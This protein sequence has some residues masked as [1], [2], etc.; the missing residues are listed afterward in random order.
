MQDKN[1]KFYTD[2]SLH[3][4]NIDYDISHLPKLLQEIIKELE[5][6]DAEVIGLIMSLN[7]QN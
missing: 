7:F 6:Y 4:H 3:D 1:S 2:K 5:K